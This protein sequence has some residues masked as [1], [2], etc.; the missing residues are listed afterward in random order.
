MSVILLYNCACNFAK[1]IVADMRKYWYLNTIKAESY[2]HSARNFPD[3]EHLFLISWRC[4]FDDR[5]RTFVKIMNTFLRDS[6][7]STL[8]RNCDEFN[9]IGPLNQQHHL[10]MIPH[11]CQLSFYDLPDNSSSFNI[12]FFFTDALFLALHNI[13]FKSLILR[14]YHIYLKSRVLK[15]KPRTPNSPIFL[16]TEF[17]ENI[18][19]L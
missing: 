7:G 18:P 3:F 6:F 19:A 15:D 14:R 4:C 1:K 10:K 9:I 8:W 5:W 11:H 2:I 17:A 16:A 13:R 12:Q